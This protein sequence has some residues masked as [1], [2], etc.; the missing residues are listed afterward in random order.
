MYDFYMEGGGGIASHAGRDLCQ[1]NKMSF[2]GPL[3]LQ[4]VG[5]VALLLLRK[6]AGEKIW[7]GHR[8]RLLCS[9]APCSWAEAVGTSS[10]KSPVHLRA[11]GRVAA[12]MEML[13]WKLQAA[14]SME[15]KFAKV[16]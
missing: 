8:S 9:L 14:A 1:L 7:Y 16:L 5:Q 11:R 10:A 6:H 12:E 3:V 15:F 2:D 13:K 4:D